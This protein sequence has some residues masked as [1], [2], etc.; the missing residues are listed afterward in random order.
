MTL[1]DAAG[2]WAIR[3]LWVAGLL[4]ACH[5]AVGWFPEY[6]RAVRTLFG[7][8]T[9]MTVAFCGVFPWAKKLPMRYRKRVQKPLDNGHPWVGLLGAWSA[10]LHTK[11]KMPPFWTTSK[12]LYTFY[13]VIVASGVVWFFFHNM[14]VLLK[15]CQGSK[16]KE[17]AGRLIRLASGASEVVHYSLH[18][19]VYVFL[20]LHVHMYFVY[21]RFFF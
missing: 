5:V 7:I 15:E 3:C 11:F 10:L 16:K 6:D 17:M 14:Q 13:F 1:D 21:G 19:A 20:F 18:F 12:Y 2:R 9:A 4:A 8:V